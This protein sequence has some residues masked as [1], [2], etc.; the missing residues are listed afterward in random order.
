[1]DNL[2]PLLIQVVAGGA[3]GN[4]VG[5]LLKNI[6]LTKVVQTVVGIVGGILGGQATGLLD[7]L[8]S[9][10]GEG[11]A[12]EILGNAGASGIGGALLVAI[13]GFIKKA[14][15]GAEQSTD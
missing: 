6:N 9:V 14:M 7:V 5:A 3:G 15:G 12:G 2:I 13:V 4:I 8:Q 1:M 11:G 10:L